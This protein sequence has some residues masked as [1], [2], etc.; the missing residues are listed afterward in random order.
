MAC[1]CSRTPPADRAEVLTAAITTQYQSHCHDTGQTAIRTTP[2]QKLMVRCM[3]LHE[4]ARNGGAVGGP[5]LEPS[6]SS[7]KG[8]LGNSCYTLPA[9]FLLH[10]P[11]EVPQTF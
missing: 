3:N 10:V 11:T 7:K 6:G 9:V 1:L 2:F 8:S 5:F 4:A